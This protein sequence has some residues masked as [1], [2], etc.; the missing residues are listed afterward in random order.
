M[1]AKEANAN[2]NIEKG[3]AIQQ[4][5]IRNHTKRKCRYYNRGHCKYRDQCKFNHSEHIRQV[6]LD[7]GICEVKNDVNRHWC[8][9][10][11]T[12][13]N[14]AATEKVHVPSFMLL[15]QRMTKQKKEEPGCYNCVG[16]RS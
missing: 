8:G 14:L 3:E 4:D 10:Y 15:F 16:C 5:T 1:K 12:K 2:E 11:R 13:A 7:T 9:S 6:Y